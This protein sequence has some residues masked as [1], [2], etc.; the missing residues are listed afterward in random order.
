MDGYTLPFILQYAGLYT[1]PVLVLR[2]LE[3]FFFFYLCI[4]MLLVIHV[5][6]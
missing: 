4:H 1:L 5:F 2:C 6:I 3:L